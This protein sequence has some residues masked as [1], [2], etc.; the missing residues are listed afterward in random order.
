MNDGRAKP[1]LNAEEED[2]S[3][4]SKEEETGSAA[5]VTTSGLKQEFRFGFEH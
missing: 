3:L 4:L 2:N 1:E 5:R